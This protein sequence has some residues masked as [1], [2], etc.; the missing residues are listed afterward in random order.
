MGALNFNSHIPEKKNMPYIIFEN[1]TKKTDNTF[2]I[3]KTN[4]EVFNNNDKEIASEFNEINNKKDEIPK[5]EI[6][7]EN[8]QI[9]SENRSNKLNRKKITH[10]H[11]KK[12]GKQHTGE[13]KDNARN[14]IYRSCMDSIWNSLLEMSKE[15]KIE[16]NLENPYIKQQIKCSIAANQKFFKKT[17]EEIYIDHIPRNIKCE[18]KHN[19]LLYKDTN[20][21]KINKFF[22]K[23]S[24]NNN[25]IIKLF[26]LPFEV[27]LM[28]YLNNENTIIIKDEKGNEQEYILKEFKTYKDCRIN[29]NIEEEEYTE[30][31]KNSYKKYIIEIKD[32]NLLG[33]KTKK[34]KKIKTEQ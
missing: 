20:T 34:T 16:F 25:I 5:D 32:K 29:K 8:I 19:R 18:I 14:K 26:K 22:A 12:E 28:A 31:Q 23:I 21:E 2:E 13:S 7:S 4:E 17:I 3:D 10:S 24:D 9:I 27:Y 15:R 30:E 1:I 11:E 6:I 33:K